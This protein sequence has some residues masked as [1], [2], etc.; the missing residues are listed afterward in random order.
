MAGAFLAAALGTKTPEELQ[1]QGA[2]KLTRVRLVA[3]CVLDCVWPSC[4]VCT[5]GHMIVRVCVQVDITLEILQS[6]KDAEARGVALRSPCVAGEI[7]F[8]ISHSW[9]DSPDNKFEV[10]QTLRQQF[11]AE[12]GREPWVWLD[13]LCI[14]QSNIAQDLE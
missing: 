2:E 14:D 10:L 8:F 7:D 12:H 5:S 1:Q 11:M 3:H 6:S 13:K 9:S 4:S